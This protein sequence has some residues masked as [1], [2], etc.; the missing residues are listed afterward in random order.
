MRK[1]TS[2]R[3]REDKEVDMRKEYRFDYS[4]ARPNRFAGR[5]DDKQL[6][7]L[8][9]A[10]VSEIFSTSESVNSALRAL[11]TAIPIGAIP[12]PAKSRKRA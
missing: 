3:A 4:Q 7:V 5:I 8:I 9:D 10:D 11:L 2:N 1:P 6:V 12:K